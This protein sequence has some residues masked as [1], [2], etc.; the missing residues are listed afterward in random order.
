VTTGF[1]SSL[2]LPGER[3]TGAFSFKTFPK[4]SVEPNP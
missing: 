1:Q 3:G 4:R 2:A